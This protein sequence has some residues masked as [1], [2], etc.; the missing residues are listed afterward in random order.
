MTDFVD[1]WIAYTA[2]DPS[3]RL[4][5]KWTGISLVA[6]ALNRQ[7]FT[8]YTSDKETYP[9]LFVLLVGGPATGKSIAIN[10][11]KELIRDVIDP[12]YL[13]PDKLT[14]RKLTKSMSVDEKT[15]SKI[16]IEIDRM[17]IDGKKVAFISEFAAFLRPDDQD[18]MTIMSDLWDCPAEFAYE[19]AHSGEDH[20]YN[21][22]LT[23]LG[24]TQPWWFGKLPPTAFQQG[25][26]TRLLPV[27][28]DEAVRQKLFANKNRQKRE[29]RKAVLQS[30]WEHMQT[31]KGEFEWLEAAQDRF[32]EWYETGEEP[33][34]T[35]PLLNDYCGRRLQMV[36][37]LAMIS[38]VS[39]T[40]KL[41]VGLE[42]VNRALD[43][44]FEAEATMPMALRDAGASPWHTHEMTA[45]MAVANSPEPVSESEVR[46][47]LGRYM[48]ATML[49]ASIDGL[50]AQGRLVVVSGSAPKRTFKAGVVHE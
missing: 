1:S 30:L 11:A 41:L 3:P 47:M 17:T 23:I 42:D 5:R 34:P 20:I 28:S 21:A 22:Y 48:P 38:A 16:D 18:M 45:V 10:A 29:E 37:K 36:A 9:N 15:H 4:F 25:F 39:R 26:A 7:T 44:L 40:G 12:D 13:A 49:S 6:A 27:Y 50:V 24:A 35:L 19:T 14:A 33:R 46:R 8:N 2:D 32:A 31:L 43:W